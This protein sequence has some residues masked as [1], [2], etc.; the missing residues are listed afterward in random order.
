MQES[1]FCERIKHVLLDNVDIIISIIG[2]LPLVIPLFYLMPAK[3]D[4]SIIASAYEY[5]LAGK[6]CLAY[7]LDMVKNTYNNWQGIW[8]AQF[9]ATGFIYN[10]GFNVISY[11][12][13]ILFIII[14]L[15]GSILYFLRV[16]TKY[17]EMGKIRFIFIPIVIIGALNTYS[18]DQA[19]YWFCSSL[20]YL[21]HFSLS[22][23]ALTLFV[24][25][26]S[27]RSALYLVISSIIAFVSTGGVLMVTGFLNMCA[28]IMLCYLLYSHQ[29]KK[30][31]LF[32]FLSCIVGA[33]I[34]ALAPGNFVRHT[35]II[36]I[37]GD[38]ISNH[39]TVS[40]LMNACINTIKIFVSCYGKLF[41]ISFILVV[42]C[43]CFFIGI[44]LKNKRKMSIFA[45][46]GG[47]ISVVFVTIFPIA[48][49]YNSS[50]IDTR[51]QYLIG[52]V[53]MM[54]AAIIFYTLGAWISSKYDITI[55]KNIKTIISAFLLCMA[56]GI[57]VDNYKSSESMTSITILKE[58]GSGILADYEE[59]Y[60]R[61]YASIKNGDSDDI[62]MQIPVID[63]KSLVPNNVSWNGALGH[64]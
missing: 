6:S 51:S 30:T 62:V 7:M 59:S 39:S 31:Q 12:M 53:E 45:V 35:R 48:Y 33:L 41:C 17:L 23:F 29:F 13:G 4:Y 55:D 54:V 52:I 1:K 11:R 25:Y 24:K 50:T 64:L 14:C 38:S 32:F 18:G 19:I 20:L 26:L 61:I 60:R 58:A 9:L 42:I 2:I 21:F 56:V 63:T 44:T 40:L 22:L 49:G 10:F 46:V 37:Q 27:N 47:G 15:T 43:S 34:N 5:K 28:L 8:F 16:V 57:A 3:D 36:E